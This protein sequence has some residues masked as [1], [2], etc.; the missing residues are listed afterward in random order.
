MT[1]IVIAAAALTAFIAAT[2]AFADYYIVK[3]GTSCKV[4]DKKPTDTKI[5]VVGNK[6]YKTEKEAQDE[7]KVVCK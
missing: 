7:V 3:E 5:V 4:V 6:V 2:P 1:K